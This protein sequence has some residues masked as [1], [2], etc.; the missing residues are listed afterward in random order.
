[1][2]NTITHGIR[3]IVTPK[4]EA[5]HSNPGANKFIFSYHV[6]IRNEGEE[7]ATLISRHWI[8]IN[9]L[10]KVEEVRGAGVVGETPTIYP[11][12]SFEYSSFCPLDTEWGTMEGTYQMQRDDGTIFDAIIERFLLSKNEIKH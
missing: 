2:S 1:M 4:Y 5:E 11:R 12:D 7:V 6:I 8:I 10:G 3:I 9:S